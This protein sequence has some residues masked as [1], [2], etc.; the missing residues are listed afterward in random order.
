LA[1]FFEGIQIP[2]FGKAA[3]SNCG[4]SIPNILDGTYWLQDVHEYAEDPVGAS[5]SILVI[6]FVELAAS[7]ERW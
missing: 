5:F 3:L 2:L 1:G 6:G 7:M 4:P